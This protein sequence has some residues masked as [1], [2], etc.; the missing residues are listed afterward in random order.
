[1]Q[2]RPGH[3]ISGARLHDLTANCISMICHIH[4][5]VFFPPFVFVWQPNVGRFRG[6]TH[7]FSTAMRVK[8]CLVLGTVECVHCIVWDIG[9]PWE[10]GVYFLL[11]LCSALLPFLLSFCLHPSHH[12]SLRYLPWRHPPPHPP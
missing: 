8:Y 10:S 9:L 7:C 6:G 2:Q 5:G 3:V 1:M 11:S 4:F 12:V